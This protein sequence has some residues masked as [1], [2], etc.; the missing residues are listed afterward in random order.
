M[1]PRTKPP[2]QGPRS[3]RQSRPPKTAFKFTGQATTQPLGTEGSRDPRD[4]VPLPLPHP[5]TSLKRGWQDAGLG[6]TLH[7]V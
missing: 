3:Q 2:N 4:L 1:A 7:P 6:R 5:D